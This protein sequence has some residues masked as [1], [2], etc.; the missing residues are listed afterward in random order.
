M[1]ISKPHNPSGVFMEEQNGTQC[2]IVEAY[3]GNEL[4]L[5]NKPTTEVK[6]VSILLMWC[7]LSVWKTRQSNLPISQEPRSC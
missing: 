7:H 1:T 3:G 2:Y 4:I 6:H 5:K